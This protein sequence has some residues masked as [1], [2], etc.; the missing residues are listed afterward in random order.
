MREKIK[1]ENSTDSYLSHSWER[2]LCKQVLG[3]SELDGPLDGNPTIEASG[4]GGV[5]KFQ[6]VVVGRFK[7]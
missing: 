7:C 1:Q 5:A 2:L 6:K 4:G 3:A